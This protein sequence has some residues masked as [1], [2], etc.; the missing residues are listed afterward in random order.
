MGAEQAA[1]VFRMAG[2][3][4]AAGLR[5]AI[6]VG[7]SGKL[8]RQLKWANDQRAAFAVIYGRDEQ[9][10]GEVTV[11]DMT[12]GNQTRLPIPDLARQLQTRC[13]GDPS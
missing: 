3:L 4:R 5:T 11:R 10:A 12:S 1:D 7:G 8:G 9:A 2:T 6:Y 13:L